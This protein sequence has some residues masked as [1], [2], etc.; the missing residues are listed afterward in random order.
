MPVETWFPTVIYYE[1]LQVPAAVHEAAVEAARNA[2]DAEQLDKL[3][4]YTAADAPNTFHHQ[5]AIQPLLALIKPHI[6]RFVEE[7]LRLDTD[8]IDYY[9]GRCWPVLQTG[10]GEGRLHCHLGATISGVFYLEIPEGAGPLQFE[11]PAR[12][13]YDHLKKSENNELNF[14]YVEYQAV[15]PNVFGASAATA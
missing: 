14:E 5:A 10:D 1:D 12:S 11:R 3:K 7:V 8:T 2:I 13:S 4:R 9:M 15:K 6:V